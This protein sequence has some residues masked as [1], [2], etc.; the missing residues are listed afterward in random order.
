V[1]LA[2]SAARG[3]SALDGFDPNANGGV[4]VIVVQP[5]GKI[6]LGGDFT[7]IAGVARNYIARLNPDGTLDTA[8]NPNASDFVF[9]IALQAD[10]KI[11]VGGFFHGA[12][13]IGGQA[14]NFIARLDGITGAA[15]SFDPHAN[16]YV[17]ALAVQAD[18]RILVGGQFSAIGGQTR[19]CMARL[20]PTTG[21]ADSFDLNADDL[22]SSIV[23]QAD[24]KILTAGQFDSIG[25]QTRH[26]VARLDAGTGLAD[27]FDPNANFV[28]Y[29]L[30]LQADGK[31]LVAGVFTSIGGQNRARLARLDPTTGLADSFNPSPNSSVLSIAVQADGKILTCGG[32]NSI[33][34]QLRNH[35]ARL[36][37]TGLADS[38]DPSMTGSSANALAVQADGKILVG[39]Y[40]Q[41]FAP[42]GGATVNRSCIARLESDGRVDQ[43]LNPGSFNN[44]LF[45]T[46]I[47]PDGKILL[48]GAFTSVLGVTRNRMARLNTDGTLDAGFNPNANDTVNAILVQ[49]DGKILVGGFFNG[50]NG[51]GG[52]TRNRIARL[53]PVTGAADSFDPNA[54]YAVNALAVQ[55]DGQI[56]AGGYFINIGGQPRRYIARL[57]PNTGLADSFDPNPNMNGFVNSIVV[58]ADTRILVGGNFTSISGQARG[59]I[60]RFDAA[61]GLVD[62]FNPNATGSVQC[63]ALQPDGK[64]LAGG[65]FTSIGGQP[66]NRIA[67][68][69][70]ATGL[71]DSFNPDATYGVS[72]L[73]VQADGKILVAG[74]NLISIGGQARNSIARLDGATGQADSFD[75]DPDGSVY[76]LALQADGKV[77]AGG[78]LRSIGGQ[79]RNF[80]S[81]LTN[82]T[83]ALQDLLV[84]Q[85]AI[86]WIRGGS[87]AQFTRVIFEYSTD[88]VNY[89]PLGNGAPVGSN[90][91]LAG[92]NLPTGQNFYIRARG[93]CGSGNGGESI[94]ESVRIA[95]LA[96][97]SPTVT[98]TPPSTPTPTPSPTPSA[99]AI[100]LSTRMLVQTGDRVGIGGFIITGTAPKHVLLRAIG[101]SLTQLGVPNALGDPVMELHG[102]A[103][104]ATITNDNWRDDPAQEAA[105]IATG[106]PPSNDLESAIDVTLN[107]GA[108]TAIVSGKNNTSGVGLVEVYDLSQT[109]SAKLANISTRAFVGTGNDIVIAGFILGSGGMDN[110]VARG[111]GPSLSAVGVPNALVDPA[112]E[113]RDANGA[114]LIANNDWQDDAGQAA[115]IAAAGLAPSHDAEAAIAATLAPG[116]YTA[117]LSGVNSGTGI[118]LVEVYDRGNG[119][120]A[121]PTPTA[122]PSASPTP[123]PS[124]TATPSTSATPTVTPSGTPILTPTPSPSPTCLLPE[125]FDDI[126]TL[127]TT[128]WVQINHSDTVGTTGWFQGNSALFPAHS[129]VVNSY[130]G[131]NFNNTATNIGTINNWL[132][133]PPLTLENGATM[134]FYTRT[135]DAPMFPDRLQVRMSTNG[136]STNVGAI[137]T[138]VGDFT[139]LL[140]DLNPTYTTTG[141]PNA[142]TRFTV[143]VTGVASPTTGRLAFRYFVENGGPGGVN[144]DNIGIDT[145]QFTGT[146]APSPTPIPTATPVATPS[147]SP[148]GNGKISFV[149]YRGTFEVGYQIVMMEADGSN[150]TLL[151][152][153]HGDDTDPAWSSDGTRIAF[154]RTPYPMGPP[155]FPPPTSYILVL[156]VAGL[157]QALPAPSPTLDSDPSWSPDDTRIAYTSRNEGYDQIYVM[158]ANGSN[159]GNLTNNPEGDLHPAWS[160]DGA[161]IAFTSERDGDPEIYLMDATSLNQT[162]LTNNPAEDFHPAWS[163]DGTRLAFT[164]DRDGNYEIYVMNADGS[165]PINLTN[166]PGYDSDPAWSPDGTKIAF[167]SD[168]DGNLEIYVMDANGSNPTNLTNY[169]GP[170]K[171]SAWQRISVS[172]PPTAT[173]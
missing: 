58:Q 49:A 31:I 161:R 137:P 99:R 109:G 27:S 84:A 163:P 151:S 113:L 118:G 20:D 130:I 11:L 138:S 66:R 92:L 23:V 25:G 124:A 168:R 146:C 106:I 85:T 62:S 155:P 150:Q 129:G 128:G 5:D 136:L 10:G 121:P 115:R 172:R 166:N 24:G 158:D 30:A 73:V 105:I 157:H 140:L 102:P 3:Q 76:A 39:G 15:D 63:I 55:A 111:I 33:G 169:P 82:D 165:N 125:G 67:R 119:S 101:P 133:T 98:P 52:Q 154:T 69:D 4:R 89:T 153:T 114:L 144:S 37:A 57:D 148:A 48:G 14:R 131:A 86:N 160:P 95:F 41:R 34:G 126:A 26:H 135:V 2:G 13:S 78:L 96:G 70:G 104:F 83:A 170:D 46:A 156:Q 35:I 162:R 28:A 171:Q 60:A 127:P 19:N 159:L 167:T 110:I 53:D 29:S 17:S 61:T 100:N 149:S 117:L 47:Q 36:D 152:G 88:S 7:S 116:L 68:L 71:A 97:P 45:T 74:G 112:L 8:F 59:R 43:T 80:S 16:A 142:W 134:S 87:S 64:I 75:P 51:I 143:T 103:G 120:G 18:G 56:L 141:Y 79:R 94:I 164:S 72:S 93:W 90:W 65:D 1:L 6:L 173:P 132:L 54:S 147:P 77:L 32:F 50:P 122:T 40:F 38:F 44:S 81:R 145:F 12:N 123:T 107:P 42:Y 21:L 9:A 22:V 91:K 139:A 108:Y